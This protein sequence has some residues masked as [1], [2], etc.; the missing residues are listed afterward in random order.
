MQ[1]YDSLA[2]GTQGPGR[3]HFMADIQ[4]D[5]VFGLWWDYSASGRDDSWTRLQQG[6]ARVGGIYGLHNRRHELVEGA[7]ERW[8][9][10]GCL[11][12]EFGHQFGKPGHANWMGRRGKIMTSCGATIGRNRCRRLISRDE[13]PSFVED[14]DFSEAMLRGAERG[15]GGGWGVGGGG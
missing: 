14:S 6:G 13:P 3:A 11:G 15:A 2:A 7:R 9:D 1:S 8:H 4:C 10:G 5:Q 12:H